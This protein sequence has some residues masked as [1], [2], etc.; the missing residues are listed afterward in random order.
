MDSNCCCRAHWRTTL[1]PEERS[2]DIV[3]AEVD[4]DGWQGSSD[5]VEDSLP[6]VYFGRALIGRCTHGAWVLFFQNYNWSKSVLKEGSIIVYSN[7]RLFGEV[8]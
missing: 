1:R 5:E 6:M 3:K 8:L 7:L 2:R 4:G